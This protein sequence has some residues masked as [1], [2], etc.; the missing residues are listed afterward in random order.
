MRQRL[1]FFS[2]QGYVQEEETIFQ[3][4]SAP[5]DGHANYLKQLLR[6]LKKDIS[7]TTIIVGNFKITL[8]TFNR[9]K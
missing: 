7:N 9:T 8:S 3:N 2:C 4:V 1:V 5:S 6:N